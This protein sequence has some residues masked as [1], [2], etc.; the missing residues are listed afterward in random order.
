MSG[1]IRFHSSRGLPHSV[2]SP[3][4]YETQIHNAFFGD[5]SQLDSHREMDAL[6]YRPDHIHR[7]SPSADLDSRRDGTMAAT[8]RNPTSEKDCTSG[9]D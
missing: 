6:V 2:F 5:S 3:I 4:I 7:E 9:C 8:E 1:D